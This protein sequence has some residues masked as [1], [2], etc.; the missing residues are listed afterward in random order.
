MNS[1]NRLTTMAYRPLPAVIC[2]L[3]SLTMIV[4]PSSVTL[5]RSRQPLDLR[6]QSA[7]SL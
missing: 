3:I 5:T 7:G 4:P 2:P 1:L 6:P